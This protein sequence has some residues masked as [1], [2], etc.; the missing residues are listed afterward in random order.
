MNGLVMTAQ[1][2]LSL[3]I[4]IVVHEGGHFL[5]ARTFGIKV[6]KFYLFFDFL[7]PLAN[8]L[9]F[10]IVKFKKGDTEYGL[11]WFP[12][13]G[14]VKIAGMADESMD[15]DQMQGEPQPWEFRT[16]PA[17][18]RLIVMLGGIIVNVITGVIIFT[19]LTWALGD[20]SIPM[21]YINNHGGIQALELAEEIGLQTGDK[22]T[23]I[24]GNSVTSLTDI[25]KP[26]VFLDK[27]AYFTVNRNMQDVRID[28]PS[29]FIER[30]SSK[31]A[32]ERFIRPRIPAVIE[33]VSG[34]TIA[35]R[36]GLR[37]GDMFTA[38]DG[39]PIQYFDEIVT[40][41]KN[42]KS[43]SV[44]LKIKRGSETLQFTEA[45]SGGEKLIGFY[46]KGIDR[47]EL[48][49]TSYSLG[50]SML[51]GPVRAFEVIAL[52]IKGF[53]KMF[54]GEID[55]RKSLSGPIGMAQMY[56]T[57]WDWERFWRMTGLL[58]MVLAFMNLLPIPALDG[59][60]VVFLLF[61]MIT[62]KEP[63]EKFMDIALKIGFALLMALMV[64]I[65]YN[66]IT[67]WILG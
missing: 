16:K 11:G 43:D 41:L 15:K 38:I 57:T 58:S 52:Q 3:S 1:L 30:F 7:F 35:S 44:R 64:F 36:I 6:E 60:Y 47:K 24:N 45:F 55:V 4:L 27:G 13:G 9:N 8:V 29:N 22:I 40:A 18:Q 46:P 20:V 65:F 2:L 56:G 49:I 19:G 33:T 28:I 67:R 66:D 48:Q 63:S 42:S 21:S 61:E 34:G 37:E 54:S 53:G 10:S 51:I 25:V 59:G 14:Y 12:L 62:G 50:Q 31:D 26:E 5:A 39:A 32:A 23:G 17:W